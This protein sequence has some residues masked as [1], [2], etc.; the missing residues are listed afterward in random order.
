M[1][2]TNMT[3]YHYWRSSSSWRV[4]LALDH[5]AL[6]VQYVHVGLLDGE[7]EGAA[8]KA[9]HPMGYVPVLEIKPGD[10]IAESVAIL[11]WLEEVYGAGTAALYPGDAR[12]RAHI[13]G[14]CELINAGT[15]PL[16]NLNVLDAL[17]D[18]SID[19]P[20]RTEWMRGFMD[21]GLVAF[22]ALAQNSAGQF[23]VGHKPTAADFFLWPQCDNAERFGIDLARY[24]LIHRLWNVAKQ[25]DCFK[26]THPDVYKPVP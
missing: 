26:R 4:R 9:R 21:Q 22:Q 14:L 13:R 6:A 16:C 23:C 17:S 11:E 25:Q 2:Q 3:L 12:T 10:Y 19:E 24:P 7:N 15:Q 18:L 8:H 5:K 1:A 20:Q